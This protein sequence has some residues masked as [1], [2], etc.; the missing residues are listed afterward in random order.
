MMKKILPILV[1]LCLW[2][3]S[4][5]TKIDYAILS[6]KIANPTNANITIHQQDR[7]IDE[8]ILSNEG[9]FIDTIKVTS[10]YYTLKHGRQQVD[11]FLNPGDDIKM[12]MNSE[13][14][15]KTL[16]F[17]G[18]GSEDNLFLVAKNKSEAKF[19]LN[20]D[21]LYAMDENDFL[22]MMNEVK[23]SK[24][25]FLKAAEN[26][27][28]A[29]RLSEEKA[30]ENEFLADLENYISKHGQYANLEDYQ[31]SKDMLSLIESLK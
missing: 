14:L 19:N 6:G 10:G 2:S 25:E 5:D 16:E 26:I 29:L 24:V 17:S 1:L 22:A 12:S 15:N 28:E 30:I 21:E 11:L 18:V 8:I 3:C 20:Y 4:K 7:K 27:S 23:S 31:P 9:T 13:A